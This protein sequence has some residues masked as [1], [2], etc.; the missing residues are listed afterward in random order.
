M[1]IVFVQLA[2]ISSSDMETITVKLKPLT[3]ADV[4]DTARKLGSG[5]YGEVVVCLKGLKCAR[6]KP[7]TLF[8]NQCPPYKQ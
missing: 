4:I 2:I 1:S 3:Q 5:A 8:F 6:K 7:H